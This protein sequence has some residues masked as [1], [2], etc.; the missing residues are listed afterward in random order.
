MANSYKLPKSLPNL[1][2]ESTEITCCRIQHHKI[3]TVLTWF[4]IMLIS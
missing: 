1:S 4:T 2:F 3:L